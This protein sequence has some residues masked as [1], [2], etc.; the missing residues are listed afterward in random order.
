MLKPITNYQSAASSAMVIANAENGGGKAFR[1][2]PIPDSL[3]F[4]IELSIADQKNGWFGQSEFD[5]SKIYWSVAYTQVY[6]VSNDQSM[7]VKGKFFLCDLTTGA[8]LLTQT[9]TD[10]K[11]D[12]RIPEQ[13][14][15]FQN[16]PN[17]FNPTTTIK[18]TIPSS[19]FTSLKI[20][21]LL[22]KEVAVLVN[23][24][25]EAGE[26]TIPFNATRLP[27][28]IYFYQLQSGNFVETKKMLLLK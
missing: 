8:I 4:R 22:G 23:E 14:S 12:P 18:F 7:W 15:L 9:M 21:D 16:F 13:F 2:L 20:F 28:G 5:T 27:S 19:N 1:Q 26:F 3:E 25:K 17:P 24:N 6:Q 10:V 11:S